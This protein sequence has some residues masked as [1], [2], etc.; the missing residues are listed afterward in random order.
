M[1]RE[2]R[3]AREAGQAHAEA[4]AALRRA[5]AER[6]RRAEA[7]AEAANRALA[8]ALAAVRRAEA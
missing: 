4:L 3:D 8:E 6:Q 7:A 1:S 2:E 5:E